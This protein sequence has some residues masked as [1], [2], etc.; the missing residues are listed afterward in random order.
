MQAKRISLKTF[1]N[2]YRYSQ[3]NQMTRININKFN[4]LQNP[5]YKDIYAPT[6]SP[7]QSHLSK[8]DQAVST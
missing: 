1:K 8:V 3:I 2:T 7:L 6:R 5:W 4:L